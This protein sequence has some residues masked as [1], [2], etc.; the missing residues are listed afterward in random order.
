MDNVAIARVLEEVADVLE[1]QDANPFRIRAYRNAVRT[2]ETQTVPLERLVAEG[3][4]LTRLAGIGKEMESHIRE[5]VT[6]GTLA[7]RDE[8]LAAVPR[9]LLTLMRLPGVGPKKA[10][11]LFDE[12]G[13]GSVDELEEAAKAG[14]VATLPGFGAKS[15]TK[16]LAGIAE[17]RQHAGRTLLAEAERHV[18]PLLAYLRQAPGIER[19]EVAGSYRRRLETI[20]DVDLLATASEPGPVMERFLHYPQVDQVL[21]SG[22]TRSS[23]TLGSGLQVDLRVVPPECY[24]AALLYFTGAKEHNVKL[25]RRAVERGLRISEYGVFRLPPGTAETGAEAPRQEAG[26]RLAGREEEDV[27]AAVG[28]SFIPPELREDHG[29]IE[30]AASGKLPRLI[31]L[32]DLRGDLQMHSTWSD[33]RNT[34]EEMVTACAARGYE[35]MAITDHSKAL[36]MVQGL[37]A[38]RLREQW[39]EIDEIRARH[40]EI[41]LLRSMEIDI[42]ADG[43]LDLEE[44]M[45]AGLDLVVVSIHSRFELP[46]AEQTARV[47]AALRHPEVDVLAHPTGRLINRRK[48]IELDVEAVLAE[49]AR[50]GVAVE[51]N[52]SPDRLDLKDVHLRLARELGVRIVISTDAHRTSELDNLRRGVEQARRAGLVA[53]DVLNTL[54]LDRFL[55]AIRR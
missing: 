46:A 19:L 7:Y 37:D 3:A 52:A 29:E 11:R 49:A 35:Y 10:K 41:R 39:K 47:L 51:L 40:P 15:Q 30:A 43:S 13:V 4:P 16:I 1:I 6:T 27:Y 5:M 38:A 18:E 48:P 53:G 28:L 32:A 2:V 31:E 8:L 33:G 24:G 34:L 42:L 44:E 21:M 9:S 14:R 23:I 12:L 26:E 54:P 20:G 55:E 17:Y 50:R 45:L 36:A 25:R 22:G